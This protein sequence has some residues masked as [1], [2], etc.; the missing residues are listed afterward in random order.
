MLKFKTIQNTPWKMTCTMKQTLMYL[1]M[2]FKQY[3]NL[4]Q[5]LWLFFHSFKY[6]YNCLF[7]LCKFIADVDN[8]QTFKVVS[9]MAPPAKIQKTTRKCHLR[10]CLLLPTWKEKPLQVNSFFPTLFW[11]IY[12]LNNACFVK[13]PKHFFYYSMDNY[14]LELYIES[15]YYLISMKINVLSETHG[16][17]KR[18]YSK[19]WI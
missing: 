2:I 15:H 1:L 5:K 7:L 18:R 13:K 16:G 19:V 3:F 14:I 17:H 10:W 9:H 8:L 6:T 12:F 4:H 11:Y